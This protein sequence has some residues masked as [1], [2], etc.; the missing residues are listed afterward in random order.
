LKRLFSPVLLFAAFL[1][2]LPDAGFSAVLRFD[3]FEIV[4]QSAAIYNGAQGTPNPFTDVQLT[5]QVTAPSGKIYTAH[6]F[7][8]GDGASGQSGNVFKIR[9]FADEAGTWQWLTSSNAAGLGGQS[10]SFQVSGTLGGLFAQG[11]VEVHPQRP[12]A[13]R[14]RVGGA[15]YLLAKYLD[16][17]APANIQFTHTFLS[18]E[19][20]DADRQAFLDRHAGM[21]LNKINV[22]LANKGDYGGI[23]TT[24]WVGTA[25][26]N[27]KARFDLARWR[28]YEQWVRQM[29]DA[30]FA[31]Q[32]W[33]FADNS[34]FGE[35]S[36]AERLPLIRYAMA[37]L[38]GLTNTIFTLMTEWQEGWSATEVDTAMRELQA[39]N[40][41]KRLASIHGLPGDFSF[42]DATWADHMVVQTGVETALTP[43]DV[44]A[45]TLQNRALANK[46]L[47]QEEFCLGQESD[48]HRQMAW[49]AFTAGA[50]GT[51]TGA[52]L[53]PLAEFVATVPFER[54][55]PAD[56]LVVSG[57][58][59]G[60]AEVGKSY[61]FYLYQGGAITA[62][63]QGISG[64]VKVD[65][66]DPRTG[67]FQAAPAVTG[68]GSR[69]FTAPGMGDWV[70]RLTEDLDGP[71]PPTDEGSFYTLAPCRLIDT[72]LAQHAPALVS[73]EIR[74]LDLTGPCGI[75]NDAMALSVNVTVADPSAQG[76]L[77]FIPGGVPFTQTSTI[78]FARGSNRAN[79]AILSLAPNGTGILAV[80]AFVADGGPVHLILDV[81]GYFK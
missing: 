49:A 62:N 51:G 18:E 25:D 9:V 40:P 66:F 65:W 35:M 68:G 28:M 56:S 53:R 72:R 16:R 76:N 54:M 24:P 52:F 6:G 41:W 48:K 70:L 21:K 71:P 14:Y 67:T 42:P 30:G 58:A 3:T 61:V 7:F 4:L 47:M 5:A 38:S 29:R 19:K 34:G 50:A 59:W 10:G 79:N 1:L 80:R 57:A 75:P 77:S 23:S 13:F 74:Q 11:P 27:D 60:L 32:I 33:L 39:R 78:N 15:V 2:A 45:D 73:S 44:H 69:S 17:A 36:D 26:A 43:A 37:R 55:S 64:T 46:P 81:N 8:D 22:Y 31:T 20:S 63:L 12:R